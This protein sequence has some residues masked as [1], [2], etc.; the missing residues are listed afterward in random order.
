M[1]RW[2]DRENH[3]LSEY[4]ISFSERLISKTLYGIKQKLASLW[5][6]QNPLGSQTT[7]GQ[8]IRAAVGSNLGQNWTYRLNWQNENPKIGFCGPILD[9]P[10]PVEK[11]LPN[12]DLQN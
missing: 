10:R 4:A 9:G 12:L 6:T 11:K 7:K 2:N 5:I 3:V 8:N 1:N